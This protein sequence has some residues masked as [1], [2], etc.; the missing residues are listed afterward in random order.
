MN[1]RIRQTCGHPRITEAKLPAPQFSDLIEDGR[2]YDLREV[3]NW[4]LKI[5]RSPSDYNRFSPV[6]LDPKSLIVGGVAYEQYASLWVQ[7]RLEA[8]KDG[9][10]E[11]QYECAAGELYR[12][13]FVRTEH[14]AQSMNR[15]RE[16]AEDG[17]MR[18]DHEMARRVM[19][20]RAAVAQ[21]SAAI[22]L[23]AAVPSIGG[24][25]FFKATSPLCFEQFDC[26]RGIARARVKQL[27]NSGNLHDISVETIESSRPYK[28]GVENQHNSIITKELLARLA[29]G[30]VAME[31]LPR[32]SYLVGAEGSFKDGI[33]TRTLQGGM[34]A[35]PL[36]TSAYVRVPKGWFEKQGLALPSGYGQSSVP[37]Q[38]L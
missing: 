4:P 22:R 32:D 26:A 5:E 14:S 2:R 28:V 19:Q 36:D 35:T 3:V 8:N 29:L 18:I 33:E 6:P 27:G 11:E 15:L 31:I 1:S 9:L 25:E 20:L 12:Q 34:E 30:N 16:F 17:R 13:F 37:S 38:S 7:E 10:T 23:L 21:P 24:I